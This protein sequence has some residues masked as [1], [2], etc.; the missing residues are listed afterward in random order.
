MGQR[1]GIL[2]SKDISAEVGIHATWIQGMME[3]PD[4][5]R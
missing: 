4:L 5:L 3:T 1:E 2:G